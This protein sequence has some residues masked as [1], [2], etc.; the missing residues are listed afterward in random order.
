MSGERIAAH[1]PAH[2]MLNIFNNAPLV[3]VGPDQYS[4]E[5]SNSDDLNGDNSVADEMNNSEEYENFLQL[6]ESILN[7]VPTSF[8]EA[9]PTSEFSEANL[10]N[11]SE[12]N[13][14]CAICQCQYEVG[15]K[16]IILQCL[17]RFHTECVSTWF[18]R[19][20]TCPICKIRVGEVGPDGDGEEEGEVAERQRLEI[21]E[22]LR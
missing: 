9:L 3:E 16:Y 14:Q 2:A 6:D 4:D 11:F 8:I 18:E 13:K 17:H 1:V 15:D 12:E 10:A 21:L 5:L 20:N 19:K 7:P 22:R